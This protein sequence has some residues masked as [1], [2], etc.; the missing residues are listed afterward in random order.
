MHSAKNRAWFLKTK[1]LNYLL[2]NK[3][4]ESPTRVSRF[5]RC[6]RRALLAWNARERDGRVACSDVRQRIGQAVAARHLAVHG[7]PVT[8]A[9]RQ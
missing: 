9:P 7:E 6:G 4:T 3:D 8:F 2:Y 5:S 1:S